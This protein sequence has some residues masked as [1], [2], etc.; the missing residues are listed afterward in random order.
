MARAIKYFVDSC[1]DSSKS[2]IIYPRR[3]RIVFKFYA[4]FSPKVFKKSEW[5]KQLIC[6]DKRVE[7][8]KLSE[9]LS[10]LDNINCYSLTFLSSNY[11]GITMIRLKA[12]EKDNQQPHATD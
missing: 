12:G 11:T 10:K 9:L 3:Y 1:Y 5:N 7:I 2:G 4:L 8:F 6:L